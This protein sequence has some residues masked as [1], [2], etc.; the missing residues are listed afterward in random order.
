LH[1][2]KIK[3]QSKEGRGT[4]FTVQLQKWF[5]AILMSKL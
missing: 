4:T 1:N 5:N 2:G 3:V